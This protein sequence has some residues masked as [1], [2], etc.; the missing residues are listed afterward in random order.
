[1]GLVGLGIKLFF[2]LEISL[3]SLVLASKLVLVLVDGPVTMV[4]VR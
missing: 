4:F 1:M 3:V 2:S